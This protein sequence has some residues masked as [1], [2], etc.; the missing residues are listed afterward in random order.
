VLYNEPVLSATH[1]DADSERAV[2]SAVNFVVEHLARTDAEVLSLPAGADLNRLAAEL[3]AHR[4]CMVVNL[5]EGLA[6]SPYTEASVAHLLWRLGLAFTGSR[7]RTLAVARNK[8]LAKKWMARKGLPTP[9]WQA[10]HS[11]II[12]DCKLAWPVIV[13]PA[14]EDASIG[15]DQGS[16]VVDRPQLE[17]RIAQVQVRHGLGVLLEEYVPGREISVAIVASPQPLALP[18]IEFEFDIEA[19]HAWPILTYDSKWQPDSADYEMSRAIY[20]ADL[21]AGLRK[22]IDALA[23]R[24]FRLLGCRDY[25]RV[26]FRIAPDGQPYI[27]EVNPNPDLS[28][29]AC[30]CGALRSANL[31]PGDWL[32]RLVETARRRSQERKVSGAKRPARRRVARA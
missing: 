11:R 32:V 3:R 28:P 6:D 12:G 5:F 29:T 19:G 22:Q 1:R 21:T 2:A 9:R 30:F 4:P 18:P 26:D 16:I 25:A 20:E 13:K 7:A 10:V 8:P 27:L 24:A 31:S 15:I 14:H 17:L 23:W